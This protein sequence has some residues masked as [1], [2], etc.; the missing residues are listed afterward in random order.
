MK[1]GLIAAVYIFA[2][3]RNNGEDGLYIAASKDGLVWQEVNGGAPLLKPTVGESKLMRDPSIVRAADGR[4]HM[5]WTTSW[6][7][8]TIGYASSTDLVNWTAQR[9]IRPFTDATGV[10]NCWAPE[11]FFDTKMREYWVVFASTIAGKFPQTAQSGNGKYNHR[12]YAMRTK[13]FGSFTPAEIFYD[14][15]FQVIDGALLE[16]GGR[17]W[18][19][20]K[21]ET[22]KPPA[23]FLFLTSAPSPRGPWTAASQ[24]ITGPDWAEGPAPLR[25]GDWWFIYYDRYADKK[26]GA[27]RSKDL[28]AWEDV[29]PGLLLP[30]GLRHGTAL[31]IPTESAPRLIIEALHVQ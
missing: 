19:V 5:V 13:D 16:H 28:A 14:P 17:T 18:M 20:A 22:L 29:T 25:V 11:I 15:G 10:M 4:F 21:N 23:K 27:M 9:E 6:Q 12:L 3:F 26:Y 2:F 31:S 30:A 8:Q 7:G 24:P 1:K